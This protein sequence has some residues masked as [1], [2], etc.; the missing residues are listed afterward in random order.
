MI[1]PI[2]RPS[3]PSVKIDG[4][5]TADD[6]QDDKDD[7]EPSQIRHEIL[8]ERDVQLRGIAGKEIQNATRNQRAPRRS[9]R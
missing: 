3:S 7:V 6:D 5:R 2:A 8:K 9:A 1:G 4:V